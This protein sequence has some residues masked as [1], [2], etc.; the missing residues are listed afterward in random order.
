[1]KRKIKE[2]IDITK[3]ERNEAY[4]MYIEGIINREEMYDYLHERIMWLLD[5]DENERDN[6]Q[7]D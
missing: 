1:M 6:S 5:S 7:L 3:V 4:R 2:L